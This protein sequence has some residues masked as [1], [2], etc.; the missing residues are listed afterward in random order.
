MVK[1]IAKIGPVYPQIFEKIRQFFGC[2]VYQTF[3]NEL[4]QLWSYCTEVHEIFS[5]IS[6]R[7]IIYAVNAHM[8]MEV[9]TSHS[10]SECLSD[11][12]G[13][14]P[15]F[16]TK[17]VAMSVICTNVEYL[18]CVYLTLTLT[19]EISEK[20]VQIDYVHPNAFMR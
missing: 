19:L 6:Y 15:F 9:A 3:T 1:K 12:S 20:E 13:H 2:V 7:G 17:L 8:H 10:I 5:T 14:L 4:C 16:S 11:E 18:M